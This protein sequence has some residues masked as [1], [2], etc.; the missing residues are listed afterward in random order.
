MA[1]DVAFAGCLAPLVLGLYWKKANAA[2]AMAAV[3][4]GSILRLLL[5]FYFPEDSRWVGVE[6]L[7]APTVSLVVM[8]FASLATQQAYPPKPEVIHQ[9]PDDA[10]VLAGIA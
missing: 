4:I 9:V 5:F 10:D 6:T 3:V 1:F 7:I 2:G 8:W